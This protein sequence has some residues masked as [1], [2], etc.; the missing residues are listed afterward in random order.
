M[1]FDHDPPPA[2]SHSYPI[3]RCRPRKPLSVTFVQSMISGIWT[4]YWGGKTIACVAPEQCDA[5]DAKCKSTWCGY[6]IAQRHEDD[7][8][9]ICALT[10]PVKTNLDQFLDRKHQL[11]GLRVR[12]VRVGVQPTSPVKVEVFGRDLLQDQIDTKVTLHIMYRLY[13]DNANKKVLD[14]G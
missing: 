13:A 3:V 1:N 2:D 5:C 4:H 7:K 12:I 14:N 11:F 9:V 8:R 10:R 6:M